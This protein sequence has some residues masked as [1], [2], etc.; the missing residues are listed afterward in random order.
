MKKSLFSLYFTISYGRIDR[1]FGTVDTTEKWEEYK[2]H[3]GVHRVPKNV[4]KKLTQESTTEIIWSKVTTVEPTTSSD[5]SM[6]N[7]G[8]LEFFRNLT[9]FYEFSGMDPDRKI[10]PNNSLKKVPISTPV[11]EKENQV[12]SWQDFGT[13]S[14]QPDYDSGRD[15]N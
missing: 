5:F 9:S 11:K 1:E 12:F 13:D 6:E 15:Q 2:K 8:R 10:I 3:H 4:P 14:Q 7:K